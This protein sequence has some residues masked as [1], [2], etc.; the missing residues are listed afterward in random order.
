MSRKDFLRT[1]SKIREIE[2]RIGASS[3]E[4]AAQKLQK[5][6]DNA[7]KKMD[8]VLFHKFIFDKIRRVLP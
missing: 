2:S 6:L 5:R 3:I 4:T 8:F 1:I 7:L